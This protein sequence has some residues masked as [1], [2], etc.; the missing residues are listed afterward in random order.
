MA[1]S[2]N[3]AGTGSGDSLTA[4]LA[5]NL[6]KLESYQFIESM[7]TSSSASPGASPSAGDPQF[8]SG[9]SSPSTSTAGPLSSF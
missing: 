2:G 5:S 8:I 6:D 7:P 3:A 4:G 1:P 9:P